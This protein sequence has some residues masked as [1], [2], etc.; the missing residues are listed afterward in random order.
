MTKKDELTEAQKRDKQRADDR[1]AELDKQAEINDAMEKFYKENREEAE[2][3]L[4]N[5]TI[6]ESGGSEE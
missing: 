6:V 1:Q 2:K 5:I 3:R 4:R